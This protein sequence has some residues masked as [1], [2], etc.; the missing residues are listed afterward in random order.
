MGACGK[1]APEIQGKEPKIAPAQLNNRLWLSKL[2]RNVK[3]NE[4]CL[5]VE[6][7][8]DSL[9]LHQIAFNALVIRLDTAKK[10]LAGP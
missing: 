1:N 6:L 8:F 4:V 3:M 2:K 5:F 9:T 7:H 10:Q